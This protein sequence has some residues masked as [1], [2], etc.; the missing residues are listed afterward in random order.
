MR[1]A[2]KGGVKRRGKLMAGTP[3]RLGLEIWFLGHCI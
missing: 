2:V 3:D 1:W